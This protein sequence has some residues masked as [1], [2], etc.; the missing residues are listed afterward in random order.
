GAY[1]FGE[2][3][4][5]R[6]GSAAEIGIYGIDQDALIWYMKE[7]T[8]RA[9]ELRSVA[10]RLKQ[11]KPL[12]ILTTADQQDSLALLGNVRV[13]QHFADQ[14]GFPRVELGHYRQMVLVELSAARRVVTSDIRDR[15]PAGATRR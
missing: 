13:I 10:A 14:P 11:G 7:P 9:E 5:Q 12:R 15:E 2:V 8:F 3:A 4:R 6:Y 1:H